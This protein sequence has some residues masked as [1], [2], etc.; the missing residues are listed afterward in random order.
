MIHTYQV[1]VTFQGLSKVVEVI[2]SGDISDPVF[3]HRIYREAGVNTTLKKFDASN[4][5]VEVI[6]SREIKSL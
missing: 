3:L 2:G 4:Y 6:N 5:K 1:K